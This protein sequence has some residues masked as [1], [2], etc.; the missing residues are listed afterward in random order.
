MI[1]LNLTKF[2]FVIQYVCISSYMSQR[3]FYSQTDEVNI[4]LSV[5][6]IKN[7]TQLDSCDG[8]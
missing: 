5:T 4:N 6:V 2:I 7:E 3:C 8:F 1:R